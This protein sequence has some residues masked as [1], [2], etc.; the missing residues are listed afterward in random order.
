MELVF[1][2][3]TIALDKKRLINHLWKLIPMREHAEDWEAQLLI[4]S[5]EI[6]GLG[7]V[8]NK[9][10]DLNFLVLLSK[11]EGLNS[12]FCKENFMLYRG[13]IFRCINLLAEVLR[14]YE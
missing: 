4:V 7:V 6:S 1:D 3:E 2:K 10:A 5:E 8:L 13:T 14:D 9:E 11:L 12:S